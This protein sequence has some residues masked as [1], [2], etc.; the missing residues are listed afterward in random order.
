MSNLKSSPLSP[1]LGPQPQSPARQ[2]ACSSPS[3]SSDHKPPRP[4]L[5]PPDLSG[6][7]NDKQRPTPEEPRWQATPLVLRGE[8]PGRRHRLALRKPDLEH[9]PAQIT[10][11]DRPT[12]IDQ[13]LT[14]RHTSA[15]MRRTPPRHSE[16][17]NSK[18][19]PSGHPPVYSVLPPIRTPR[20][21]TRN[22]QPSLN[23][24]S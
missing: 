15:S 19:P 2:R 18:T 22:R 14:D 17:P 8:P 4:A 21:Q 23:P 20:F 6:S 16:N 10:A 3:G 11:M 13:Q 12:E 5:G 1:P 9:L 7:G 24:E